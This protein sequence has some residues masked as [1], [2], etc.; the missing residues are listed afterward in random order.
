MSK[1][2]FF[3]VSEQDDLV[4]KTRR[5]DGFQP[6]H[7]PLYDMQDRESIR[8]HTLGAHEYAERVAI[9]MRHNH[10]ERPFD[11]KAHVGEPSDS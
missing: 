2:V 9:E 5:R 4:A 1:P 3:L 11:I 7:V 6:R 8:Q 10:D